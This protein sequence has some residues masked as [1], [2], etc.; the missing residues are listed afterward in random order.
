MSYEYLVFPNYNEDN[1]ISTCAMMEALLPDLKKTDFLSGVDGPIQ[2]YSLGDKLLTVYGKIRD[3]E[4]SVSSGFSI[5]Y[6]QN[7][8]VSI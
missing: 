5:S 3:N 4:V 2:N 8:P 7:R 6:L 1:F